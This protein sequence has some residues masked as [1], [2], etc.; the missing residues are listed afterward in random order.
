MAN[1]KDV[2]V[3]GTEAYKELTDSNSVIGIK[4]GFSGEF[5]SN[6][7]LRI[8][9]DFKG[10]VKGRGVVLVGENG[11]IAGDL[12]AKS[13]R[14]GGRIKG[15]VYAIN[16]VE[17]LSTGKLLG[18]LYTSRVSA[19]EGMIFEGNGKTLT[20]DEMESIFKQ[21]VDSSPPIIDEE[22]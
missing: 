3:P 6:G 10:K 21:D 12:Y 15:N 20:K 13:V 7:L 4:N 18:D 16:K 14:I 1:E 11:R 8:D 17:I 5:H 22:F 19:E 2:L 9:G